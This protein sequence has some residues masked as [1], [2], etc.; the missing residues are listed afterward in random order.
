MTGRLR[1]YSAIDELQH[2][3]S[4]GMQLNNSARLLSAEDIREHIAYDPVE[5]TFT[6]RTFRH[7]LR[8]PAG[9]PAGYVRKG[10]LAIKLFQVKVLAHRMAWTYMT[11]EWPETLVDHWDND[12]LNNRWN[13]LR[14]ATSSQNAMNYSIGKRGPDRLKG[15]CWDSANEMWQAHI[16]INRKQKNLG[17][18]PTEREAH[19]A[20]KAAAVEQFGEWARFN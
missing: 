17:R 4:A 9:R 18:Y 19:E 7:G 1:P 20:Y 12:P 6:W 3:A 10:Y 16:C 14:L 11:G 8:W 15:T 2:A 13:N 5:G